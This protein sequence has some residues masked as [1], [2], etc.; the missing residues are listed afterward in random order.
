MLRGWCSGAMSPRSIA[1][2]RRTG[3]SSPGSPRESCT[4]PRSSWTPAAEPCFSCSAA[5]AE[6]LRARL[7]GQPLP[8]DSAPLPLSASFGVAEW[9]GPNEAP[10]RLLMRA[11]Q[12]L[13][14]AK[15]GGR[16]RVQPD[17]GHEADAPAAVAA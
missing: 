5:A 13:Y 15:H 3:R 14:P 2:C 16:N 11:D 6:K 8:T 9:K 12:A 7:A 4:T 10:S 1:R 17:E